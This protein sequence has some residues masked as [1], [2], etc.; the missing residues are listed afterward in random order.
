MTSFMT[1]R[2]LAATALFMPGYRALDH[3]IKTVISEVAKKYPEPKSGN[4]G[5]GF[6][7]DYNSYLAWYYLNNK[8]N[9][10]NTS[11]W[12]RI[13]ICVPDQGALGSENPVGVPRHEPFFFIA[14]ADDPAERRRPLSCSA[15]SP[16]VVEINEGF[17]VVIA[18]PVGQFEA[19]PD[20][21]QSLITWAQEEVGRAWPTSR[22]PPVENV[23]V[24]AEG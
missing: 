2:D 24:E 17:D 10:P 13:G 21:G 9:P 19:A 18:R 1:S 23:Q 8:L 15:K 14:F 6:S 16:R 5:S 20:I 4:G 11:F 22:R 7:P 3:T 12:I